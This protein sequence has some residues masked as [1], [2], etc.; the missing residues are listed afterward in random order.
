MKKIFAVFKKELRRFFTDRRMVAGIFL[1]GILIY[2]IYSLLGGVMINEVEQEST[3]F[4]IYVVDEVYDLNEYYTAAGI[5][6]DKYNSGLTKEE[7]LGRIN[8]GTLD[9]YVVYETDFINKYEEYL[10]DK[11]KTAPSIAIY[12][13]STNTASAQIKQITV[14]ILNLIEYKDDNKFDIN[15]AGEAN[16]DLATEEDMSIMIIGMILPFILMTFLISGAIGVCSESIAG[17][18]ERGTIATLLVT[19]VKRSNLVIGKI[20]ALGV[21]SI[22]S[23]FVSFLGLVLS[24]PKLVGASFSLATYGLPAMLLLL[25]VVVVT[26][27]FFTTILT[28]ISTYARS[29]KEATSLALPLTM[30]V[31]VTGITGMASGSGT[32]ESYMYLI[33][34][35]NSIQV[36]NGILNLSF[37]VWNIVVTIISNL[38]FVGVGVYLLTKMFDSEK[39]MFN[40]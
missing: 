36:F 39:I 10:L 19:P 25:L 21:V 16:Y 31:M 26:S 13:N 33:P 22:A 8:D 28:I 38:I 17:E 35:Y 14:D 2:I 6:V 5:T 12:Y 32:P 15:P 3:E 37:N 27:L 29:V 1:P 24:L 11:T 40:K 20:A 9:L 18:K 34:I 23:A 30:I 7:A 4:T